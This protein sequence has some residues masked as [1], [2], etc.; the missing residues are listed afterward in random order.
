VDALR[1]PERL[2]GLLRVCALW[3][4][5]GHGS[6]IANDPQAVRLTEALRVIRGV[7][8]VPL[9][10]G[11]RGGRDIARRIRSARLRALRE[12]LKAQAR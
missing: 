6:R 10:A 12:W 11:D 5:T 4:R 9:A 1:R 8:A 7:K 2:A 3:R